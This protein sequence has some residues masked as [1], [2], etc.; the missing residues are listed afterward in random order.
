MVRVDPDVLKADCGSCFGLCCVA[1]PFQASTD[2]ARNKDGGTPCRN[3]QDDFRCGIHKRLRTDGWKGCTVFECFGA[4]QKISRHTFGGTSWRDA[5]ETAGTMFSTFG[6]MRQLHELL[7]YVN[8]A[9]GFPAVAAPAGAGLRTKLR[10]A[11]D[12]TL[13]L[14]LSPAEALLELDVDAHRGRVNT[15]LLEAS[16]L[17]RAPHTGGRRNGKQ[18]AELGGADLMGARLKG[19]DLRGANLRG[20]WLI[21]A[22]LRDADLR[23]ADMIGADLRDADVRGADLSTSLFLTQP[24]LNAAKGD[25]GTKVPASLE[26]PR[27][28]LSSRN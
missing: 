1:L 15:L 20:A 14:T 24:Q 17:A 12:S 11:V 6:V 18:G 25:A 10:S 21:A 3:L 19:T 28:W 9:L 7:W 26:V 4:G 13:R 8:G 16:A 2:F 5:P 23:L 27:H 22:E